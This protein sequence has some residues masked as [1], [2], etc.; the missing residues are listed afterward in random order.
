VVNRRPQ[1]ASRPGPRPTLWGHQLKILARLLAGHWLLLWDMGVGKTAAL[2][3]AGEQVGGRQ[4][5]LS[6]AAIIA[7]TAQEIARWRPKAKVQ[8]VASG[9]S[10]L[11]PDA[12]VVICSYD[13]MRTKG[14]WRQLFAMRWA[15]CVCDEGHAL[16]HTTAIRTKAFYGARRDSPGALFRC[17]DRVWVATGTPIMNYPDE[18]WPHISRLF[19]HLV[20]DLVHQ[21]DWVA[22]FCVTRQTA[23]GQQIIGGRNLGELAQMLA[24]CASRLA[25]TDVVDIPPLI[26]NSIPVEISREQRAEM[27]SA[28]P[29]ERLAEIEIILDQIEG[30]DAAAWARL[31]AM[32]LP[33]ASVRRVTALAKAPACVALA[34]T[35][36]LGGADRIAIFGSH[37]DG[38]RYVARGLEQFGCGLMI[39]ETSDTQ[40]EAARRD[41]ISGRNRVLVANTSVAG[42]GLNLQAARRCILLDCP[43]TPSALD[44]AIA[45]LHRAGQ[46]RPVHASLLSVA[47]SIDERVT[48][49]LSEKR[50]IITQIVGA[51]RA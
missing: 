37:I 26:V 34:A 48:T 24:T 46:T 19:P 50:R 8:I 36:L 42:F 14:I 5:W 27:N 38:L 47:R 49:I 9:K 33:L 28:L 7:Q 31:Q 17:C 39:G 4:L 40:R 16:G 1:H 35:E 23:Y 51:A 18:L 32:M 21:R 15:S 45:R 44:Q 29:P 41:F 12:D 3:A 30:G 25:L 20:A 10:S 43:W 13:L 22:R 11:M 2:I 6:P